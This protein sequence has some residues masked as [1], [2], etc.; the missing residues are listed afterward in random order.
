MSRDGWS[1]SE[2]GGLHEE[3]NVARRVTAKNI[4]CTLGRWRKLGAQTVFVVYDTQ[5][6]KMPL[7]QTSQG[8]YAGCVVCDLPSDQRLAK[9]LRHKHGNG[10]EPVFRKSTGDAFTNPHLA[11]FL[12]SRG[13]NRVILAGCFTHECVR[14]S[15]RGAVWN[16]FAVTLLK[17]CSYPRYNDDH[18]YD[19]WRGMVSEAG[20]G[21]CDVVV[22]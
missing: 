22:V 6:D 16:G 15:A 17:D 21:E 19:C 18:E 8:E 20:N 14:A 3:V 12:R 4:I 2:I 7:W 5:G 1:T 11:D 9:F 10:F 13:V